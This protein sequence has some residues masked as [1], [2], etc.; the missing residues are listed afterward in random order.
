MFGLL[1]AIFAL[2]Y[3]HDNER[4]DQEGYVSDL[5]IAWDKV[6]RISLAFY[7]VAE[8]LSLS[9]PRGASGPKCLGIPHRN[10]YILRT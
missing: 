8:K 3:L 2:S 5:A 10:F 9:T 6:P 1:K 7:N 4:L